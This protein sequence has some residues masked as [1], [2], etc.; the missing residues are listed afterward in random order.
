ML[1]SRAGKYEVTVTP[2]SNAAT[3]SLLC[4]DLVSSITLKLSQ[5]SNS[6]NIGVL[7]YT[8][9]NSTM[10]AESLTPSTT[11]NVSTVLENGQSCSLSQFV[12]SM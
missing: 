6:T 3:F 2:T 1:S 4:N 10:T 12:T 11:Y 7:S 8:S 9:C 5:A